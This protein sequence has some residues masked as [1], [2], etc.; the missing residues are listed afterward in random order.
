MMSFAEP[1]PEVLPSPV[2][3][4]QVDTIDLFLKQP[5]GRPISQEQLVEEVKGIYAGLEMVESKCVEVG[6]AR[7]PN[8]SVMSSD[9]E[10]EAFKK[11]C[12]RGLKSENCWRVCV[13][14]SC[15]RDD[16]SR[17]EYFNRKYLFS[18]LWHPSELRASKK[19]ASRYF[20]PAYVGRQ[21]FDNS[22]EL[23]GRRH[24]AIVP[25]SHEFL[26]LMSK[27]GVNR[28]DTGLLENLVMRR[29]VTVSPRSV[30]ISS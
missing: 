1:D 25:Y 30:Y 16:L 8:E 23:L 17:V 11:Q 28:R 7:D 9:V 6:N 3:P 21:E 12:I 24:P 2:G 14:K 22:V 27:E 29:C 18:K 5:E 19:L 4:S 10:W 20:L 13:T 26:R 15:V